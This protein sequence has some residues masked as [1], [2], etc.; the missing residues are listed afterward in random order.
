MVKVSSPG[1][2]D[3]WMEFSKGKTKLPG[4]RVIHCSCVEVESFL[5]CLGENLSLSSGGGEPIRPSGSCFFICNFKQ[6]R[7]L[8]IHGIATEGEGT[9][10]VCVCLRGRV[11][12]SVVEVTW[13]S[14]LQFFSLCYIP[15]LLTLAFDKDC[16]FS[17]CE[18]G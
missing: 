10:C 13:T 2:E 17:L 12:G 9:V 14:V 8:P 16:I 4:L 11:D 3:A 1:C 7:C 15:N 18:L 6:S 5:I